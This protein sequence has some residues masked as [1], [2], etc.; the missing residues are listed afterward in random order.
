MKL[1]LASGL[2]PVS[3]TEQVWF[4]QYDSYH[5]DAYDSTPEEL[6]SV[7]ERAAKEFSR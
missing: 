6:E 2:I 1:G 5:S 7:R 4:M 3:D